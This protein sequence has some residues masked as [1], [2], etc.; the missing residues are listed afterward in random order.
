MKVTAATEKA[1]SM[2]GDTG[3]AVAIQRPGFR[4]VYAVGVVAPSGRFIPIGAGHTFNEAFDNAA[5][6][7]VTREDVQQAA[8]TVQRWSLVRRVAF[9]GGLALLAVVVGVIAWRLKP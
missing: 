2:F 7:N 5:A 1:Q 9:F 6:A 8:V 3:R 4:D